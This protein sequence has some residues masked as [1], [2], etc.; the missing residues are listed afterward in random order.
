MGEAAAAI[1]RVRCPSDY[2]STAPVVMK[3]HGWGLPV[4]EGINRARGSAG[5]VVG[6]GRWSIYRQ[7]F[8]IDPLSISLPRP[9][10]Y[11]IITHAS[12]RSEALTPQC[13]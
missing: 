12:K 10:V 5:L 7:V 1:K 6:V 3:Y 8:L 2:P 13:D 11:E 9:S 4:A